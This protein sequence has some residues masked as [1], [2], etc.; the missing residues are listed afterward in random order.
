MSFIPNSFSDFTHPLSHLPKP[1]TTPISDATLRSTPP[2]PFTVLRLH[3]VGTLRLRSGGT[4][5]RSW[6]LFLSKKSLRGG[7]GEPCHH[8]FVAR[9]SGLVSLETPSLRSL[10]WNRWE[11]VGFFFFLHD[12]GFWDGSGVMVGDWVGLWIVAEWVGCSGFCWFFLSDLW[13]RWLI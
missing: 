9:C 1:V 8:R 5:I 12:L 2:A 11:W 6:P 7:R 10:T 4:T 13:F 3:S